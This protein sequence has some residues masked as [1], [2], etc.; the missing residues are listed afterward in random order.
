MKVL[1]IKTNGSIASVQVFAQ[2]NNEISYNDIRKLV[3]SN[4]DMLYAPKISRLAYLYVLFVE[5]G[6]DHQVNP[7]A[8]FLAGGETLI[9][10][11]AVLVRTNHLGGGAKIIA[12]EDAEITKIAEYVEK[13]RK[14]LT[15][16]T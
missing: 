8:T 2:K 16:Q 6:T 11:D 10:G 13:V 9:K 15:Q 14:K 12:L 3:T 7:V 5:K 1:I 4:A